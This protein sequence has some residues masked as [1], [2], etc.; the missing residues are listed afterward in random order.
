LLVRNPHFKPDETDKELCHAVFAT[1]TLGFS[2]EWFARTGGE[3]Y[4]AGLNSTIIPLPDIATEVK[5]SDQSINQLKACARA[6]IVGAPGKEFEILREGLVCLRF[7]CRTG[8]PANHP[9]VL[10]SCDFKRPPDS[11]SNTRRA[12]GRDYNSRRC[13]GRCL[14]CCRPW[15]VGHIASSRDRTRNVG[16]DRGSAAKCED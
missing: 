15:C 9:I 13:T 12:F 8:R 2:P 4:L 16:I 7:Y 1:D 11:I 14:H 10:P 5:A 6:M 3:L